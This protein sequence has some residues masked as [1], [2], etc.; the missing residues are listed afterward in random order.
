MPDCYYKS[1]LFPE[2]SPQSAGDRSEV[3]L[4]LCSWLSTISN[5]SSYRMSPKMMPVPG[6]LNAFSVNYYVPAEVSFRVQS[7]VIA[8]H[9][10][11]EN[12]VIILTLQVI[13]I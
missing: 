8:F 1:F 12:S 5:E 9:F 10:P 2:D 7:R 6:Y 13:D 3:C 11:P 4:E